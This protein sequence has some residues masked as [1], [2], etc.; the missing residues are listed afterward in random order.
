MA[1]KEPVV[2]R[3]RTDEEEKLT[4]YW[5]IILKGAID[6]GNREAAISM[7]KSNVNE[8]RYTRP[9]WCL[10]IAAKRGNFN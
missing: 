5:E 10:R 1:P 6:S 2:E 9:A 3:K 4:H 7:I 8:I